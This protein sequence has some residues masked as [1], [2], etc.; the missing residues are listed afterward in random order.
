[1]Y[2]YSFFPLLATREV[3]VSVG[4]TRVVLGLFMLFQD[5]RSR[6]VDGGVVG[7][8]EL[9]NLEEARTGM[10]FSMMFVSQ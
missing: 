9:Q 5:M 3:Y 4:G 10:S 8:R 7:G 2:V 6:M 1:M